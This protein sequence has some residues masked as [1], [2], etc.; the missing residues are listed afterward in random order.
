MSKKLHNHLVIAW[1]AAFFAFNR[2]SQNG[3][4]LQEILGYTDAL[5]GIPNRKAF[6]E[7]RQVISAFQ[8]FILID[9]DNLKQLNDTFGHLF[10]DKILK[11]CAHILA[12]ATEKVG[13]VYRL[14]GDEFAIIVPQCWVKT[15]CLFINNQVK[16]EARFSF[17]M[18]IAPTCGTEGLT[19]DTF[20]SAETALYQ[21]KHREPNI[22]TEFLTD[23]IEEIKAPSELHI[24]DTFSHESESVGVLT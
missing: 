7:D 18:G 22:Y 21:C 12:K 1:K 23:E 8:T 17:S 15:V 9:V 16:K 6:E 10:G 14:A 20:K 5:T 24:E 4:S 2:A 19:E 11:D 3:E 13:K